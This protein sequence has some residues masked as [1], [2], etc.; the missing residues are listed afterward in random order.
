MQMMGRYHQLGL[1][2]RR[3]LYRLVQTGRS[4]KQAAMELGR[5]PS[6][7]YREIKRNRHLDE[8]PLFR[9]YFPTIAQTKATGRRVRGAKV[10]PS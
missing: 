9:G 8:E 1:D 7:L 2:E 6:T 3:I 5:H 10:A 4:V